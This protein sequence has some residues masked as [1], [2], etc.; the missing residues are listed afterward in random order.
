[1]GTPARSR[2]SIPR[3]SSGRRGSSSCRSALSLVLLVAAALFVRTLNNLQQAAARRRRTSASSSSASTLRRTATTAIGWRRCIWISLK[4]LDAVPGVEAQAPRGCG[5]FR[6]GSA[7][8]QSRSRDAAQAVDERAQEY[9]RT[10]LPRTTGCGC[11]RAATSAGRI[12]GRRRVAVVTEA[13]ARYFFGRFNVVGRQ[14]SDSDSSTPRPAYEIRG[15]RRMRDTRRCEGRFP[16]TAYMPFTA[17]RGELHGLF[18]KL[19]AADPLAR[20]RRCA[21]PSDRSTRA[22]DRR[23]RQHGEPGRRFAVARRVCSRG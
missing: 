4:R 18:F 23:S 2:S 21:K 16:R 14:C 6:A 5:C 17:M 19:R 3:R 12:Y 15:A 8:G 10:R 1:M 7:T 20:R 11:S 13:M 22:R 9:G